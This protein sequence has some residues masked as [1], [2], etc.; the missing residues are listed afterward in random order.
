MSGSLAKAHQS[1]IRNQV[2]DAIRQARTEAGMRQPELAKALQVSVTTISEWELGKKLPSL[3]R[4]DEIAQAL[5]IN[6][7]ELCPDIGH[8][9]KLTKN[10]KLRLDRIV[11][12]GKSRV[13]ASK[14]DLLADTADQNTTDTSSQEDDRRD[15]FLI[16]GELRGFFRMMAED[17]QRLTQE[18]AELARGSGN[19]DISR[20]AEQLQEL[21][22]R[23]V[24]RLDTLIDSIK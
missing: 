23:R 4:R 2:G 1:A 13:V 3:D 21:A 18:L 11:V 9:E 20:I 7:D 22:G 15:L 19:Q 16:L 12:D 10:D 8:V 17:E 24:A 5:N 6:I 14:R